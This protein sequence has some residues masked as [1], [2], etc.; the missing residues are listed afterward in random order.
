MRIV[1]IRPA[2]SMRCVEFKRQIAIRANAV[3]PW[4]KIVVWKSH[5]RRKANRGC[6]TL[7]NLKLRKTPHFSK[8]CIVYSMSRMARMTATG[9]EVIGVPSTVSNSWR[10]A[11][12]ARPPRSVT[13]G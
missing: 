8:R 13:F 5:H 3:W 11:T 1:V 4:P 10:F 2:G 6:M 9:G 12:G 7:R